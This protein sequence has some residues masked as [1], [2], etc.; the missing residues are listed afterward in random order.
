MAERVEHFSTLT[1]CD[2]CARK[3]LNLIFFIATKTAATQYK[4]WY[5]CDLCYNFRFI[6]TTRDEP[7]YGV[8]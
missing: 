1:P 5:I 4:L 6:P 3:H 2:F 8:D 7:S